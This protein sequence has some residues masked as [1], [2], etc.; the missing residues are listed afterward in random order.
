[1]K[2]V[3][4][5]LCRN[6]ADV[7][8]AMLDFHLHQGVNF[9][10]AT[11][12]ASEDDTPSILEHYRRR[13]VLH[14]I[15]ESDLTHDQAVWVTRMARLAARDYGAD[16][17]INSDADEFWWPTEG[18]LRDVL[19]HVSSDVAALAV[20]RM[21]FLPVEREDGPFWERMTIRE[22]VSL[23]SLGKPLPPKMCHRTFADVEVND[24]NHVVLRAGSPL[25][26]I[27]AERLQ[28]LHF[29]MRSYRQFESKIRLGVEALERNPRLNPKQRPR[30]WHLLRKVSKRTSPE[31]ADGAAVGFTWKHLYYQYYRTGRLKDY[32]AVQILT[33]ERLADGIVSGS[34]V[35]DTR[36]RDFIRSLAAT[37]GG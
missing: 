26:A 31:I 5:L 6:E 18:N 20:S 36:L 12:N 27:H 3:M 24:G 16:W 21:N 2:L 34:L 32:Y 15:H 25:M 30:W 19:T 10:I 1:M 14:L 33:P 28:I 8:E 37:T 13:G 9:V 35:K 4:T 23:N 7:V 22:T 17:V 29:P 11:D